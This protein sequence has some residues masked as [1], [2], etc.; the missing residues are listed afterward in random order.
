MRALP[1]NAPQAGSAWGFVVATNGVLTITDVLY[2]TKKAKQLAMSISSNILSGNFTSEYRIKYLQNFRNIEKLSYYIH[3]E[4]SLI[5]SSN[6]YTWTHW[7]GHEKF[8]ENVFISIDPHIDLDFSRTTDRPLA[9]IEIFRVSPDS[10]FADDFLGIAL[11]SEQIASFGGVGFQEK[12]N[13]GLY[14]AVAWTDSS[15][16]SPFVSGYGTLRFDDAYTILHELGHTL[17]LSHPQFNGTDDPSGS[18][19]TSGDTVMSYNST[20]AYDRFGIFSTAPQWTSADIA[21]LQNL[22]G[23]ENDAPGVSLTINSPYDALSAVRRWGLG[24]QNTGRVDVNGS[25]SMN[26]LASTWTSLVQIKS[27]HQVSAGGTREDIPQIDTLGTAVMQGSIVDGSSTNDVIWSKAGW[28]V[29]SG[30]DG[31][32]FIRAGNGRDF[33]SGGLGADEL[34][35]DFGWNTFVSEKDGSSDLIA[36]KSDQFLS[37]WL[38][39]KA[40][41]NPNG[42]K[43]DII[44]GLDANDKIRIIGVFSP[45]ITV[46]AGATAHGVSG[47]GIYAKGALEALYTGGDLSVAQIT[48]MTSGDGSTAALANQITSYGWTG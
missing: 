27:V 8:I 26:I 32:D 46:R 21:A 35:G 14:R 44:E 33:I 45:D 18:W 13:F 2:C 15:A 47:I 25:A 6:T 24:I 9:H 36:I 28:D 17:G 34:H 4:I 41:N 31:N 11:G 29:I 12:K 3:D 1:P 10:L 22:W 38:Y 19:H 42:E 43:A 37:N 5:D 23:L 7:D 40:G 39:G 48:A 20:P 16:S 30:G